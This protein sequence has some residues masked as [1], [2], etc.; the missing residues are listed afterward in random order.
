MVHRVPNVAAAQRVLQASVADECG[1]PLQF[2]HWRT[3]GSTCIGDGATACGG[4]TAATDRARLATA[5]DQ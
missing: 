2:V 1:A 5:A 3:A 4:T